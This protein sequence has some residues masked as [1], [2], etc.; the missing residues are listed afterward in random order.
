[1]SINIILNTQLYFDLQLPKNKSTYIIQDLQSNK[2]NKSSL[3]Y[4]YAT[5]R[6]YYDF[7]KSNGYENIGLVRSSFKLFVTSDKIRKK[8]KK[9]N[10]V[11]PSNPDVRKEIK[12]ICETF[13]IELN[14][15]FDIGYLSPDNFVKFFVGSNGNFNSL[16]K[17]LIPDYPEK[18]E[19][20]LTEYK[21]GEL[22]ENIKTT[23]LMR[24]KSKNY[25]KDAEKKIDDLFTNLSKQKVEVIYPITHDDVKNS[26]YQ[27]IKENGKVDLYHYK[28]FR[29]KNTSAK[30]ES[31]LLTFD[32]GL[33]VPI[34]RGFL[35]PSFLVKTLKS[36][37]GDDLTL[38]RYLF[39]EEIIVEREKTRIL[40]EHKPKKYRLSS[41]RKINNNLKLGNT[42]IEPY[43][44]AIKLLRKTGYINKEVLHKIIINFMLLCEIKLSDIYEWLKSINADILSAKEYI[45]NSKFYGSDYIIQNTNY[46]YKFNGRETLDIL[47]DRFVYVNREIFRYSE[48]KKVNHLLKNEKER[49][50]NIEYVDKYIDRYINS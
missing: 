34:S 10:I 16:F 39:F 41:N 45:T 5:T 12:D 25:L 19:D 28:P 46:G 37:K 4:T 21:K 32:S 2:E 1:M 35:S 15:Y 36:L 20:E 29:F 30:N 3:I 50:K 24:Y 47:Y 7:L 48:R 23:N 18:P 33:D 14:F 38:S 31:N 44:D 8:V 27:F 40:V 6:Y 26:L 22:E 43:D 9:I 17:R 13:D 49:I 42:D 11:E